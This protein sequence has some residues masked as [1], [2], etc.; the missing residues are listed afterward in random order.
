MSSEPIRDSVKDQSGFHRHRLPAVQVNSI[1]PMKRQRL[2]SNIARAATAAVI[3]RLPVVHSTKK[4]VPG[5]MTLFFD[6]NR[7]AAFATSED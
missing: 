1:A 2:V 3:Y 6:M 4:T 5:F 7:S